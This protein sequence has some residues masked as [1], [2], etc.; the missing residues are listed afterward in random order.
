[1]ILSRS[2]RSKPLP[3]KWVANK[4]NG[5]YLLAM[6]GFSEERMAEEIGIGVAVFRNMR[7]NDP[8]FRDAVFNGKT[9]ANMLVVESTLANCI[10]RWIEEEEVHIWK[11]EEI[12]VK[13]KK[14]HKG[15]P[16]LQVKWLAMRV[17]EGWS[18]KHQPDTTNNTTNINY[19]IKM[20]SVDDLATLERLQKSKQIEQDAGSVD[21]IDT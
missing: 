14:F 20:L 19:D 18:E 4:Y 12:R 8:D 2:I 9:R 5:I 11:G 21:D 15:N 1:M 6:L 3:E 13:V 16:W 7:D 10:D 17:G